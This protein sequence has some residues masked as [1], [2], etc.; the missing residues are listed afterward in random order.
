VYHYTY[1]VKIVWVG[2]ALTPDPWASV[3][4]WGEF[5]II[6]EVT[7]DPHAGMHGVNRT[8]LVNPAGLG[9]AR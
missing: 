9:V 5:A 6:E 4:I 3:R 8:S 7:N 2:P 1:F